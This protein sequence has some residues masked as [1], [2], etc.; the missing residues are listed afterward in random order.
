MR[1]RGRVSRH[2]SMSSPVRSVIR[3]ICLHIALAT[4]DRT[5]KPVLASVR[6]RHPDA[7][8]PWGLMAHML[9]VAALQVYHPVSL[10]VLMQGDDQALHPVTSAI[11]IVHL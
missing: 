10:L 1:P 9:G 4:V 7:F 6:R 5:P 3:S 8:D 11:E 2:A